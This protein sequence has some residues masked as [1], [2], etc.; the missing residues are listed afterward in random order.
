MINADTAKL[1]SSKSNDDMV[2]KFLKN[3]RLWYPKEE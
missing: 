1:L 2:D 3:N